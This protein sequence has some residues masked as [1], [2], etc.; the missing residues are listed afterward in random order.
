MASHCSI[1]SAATANITEISTIV[2]IDGISILYKSFKWNCIAKTGK[3]ENEE[4]EEIKRK[5]RCLHHKRSKE[6]YERLDF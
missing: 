1:A 6:L 4:N 5:N 3:P 2:K